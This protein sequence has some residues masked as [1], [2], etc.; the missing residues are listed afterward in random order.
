[1]VLFSKITPPV[2]PIGTLPPW[3]RGY[4]E[5]EAEF[6]QTPVDLPAMV[7]LSAMAIACGGKM[8]VTVR[9]GHVEPLNLYILV[10][11]ESGSRKSPV[12]KPMMKPV[13]DFERDLIDAA[14]KADEPNL[15]TLLV[16]DVTPE[17]LSQLMAA[18][19]GRMAMAS[20]EGGIFGTMAGRYS[21]N[22]PNID[23][24]LK[25]HSGDHFIVNRK[26]KRTEIVSDPCLTISIALQPDVIRS[27]ARVAAFRSRGLLA[28]F[29]Y[30]LPQSNIGYRK[31]DGQSVPD[32][33]QS[34]YEANLKKLLDIPIQPLR[35]MTLT[36][37]AF[38]IWLDFLSRIEPRLRPGA[39]LYPL[40]D[41]A[42]KLAGTVARVA[43]LLHMADR[44]NDAAPWQAP[45]PGP[46]MER[47]IIFGFYLVEHAKIAFDLMGTDP[48]LDDALHVLIWIRASGVQV[49]SK[50]DVY[51]AMQARFRTATQAD[52]VLG[53]LE[54]RGYIRCRPVDYIGHGRK[55]TPVYDVNPEVHDGK[56]A[57]APVVAAT[58]TKP[59]Q[60]PPNANDINDRKDKNPPVAALSSSN[61]V[62]SVNSV[63]GSH[64]PA[65]AGVQNKEAPLA[66]P[67]PEPMANA[68]AGSKKRRTRTFFVGAKPAHCKL[69]PPDENWLLDGF[70]AYSDEHVCLV[71]ARTHEEA[72]RQYEQTILPLFAGD[73]RLAAFAYTRENWGTIGGKIPANYFNLPRAQ[74]APFLEELR[75]ELQ[76]KTVTA[77]AD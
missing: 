17:A 4:V 62:N 46:T 61:S 59:A 5:A 14:E 52:P 43:G 20:D 55:P 13:R 3:L 24:F 32:L 25:A 73:R 15:P 68:S 63:T 35:M 34:N 39:D 7:G 75:Q 31:V 26:G 33:A 51:R 23:V 37:E 65:G 49:F 69:P 57:S 27:L 53:E 18:N 58:P 10:A 70:Y 11:M 54:S 64:K 42:N 50:R 8:K 12:F 72:E 48:V 56:G 38:A 16:D 30:V 6:T 44:T 36:R 74:R 47:A 28:R 40:A 29:V 2:F 76:T 60:K 22:M 9:P 45:I 41:W 21:H 67:D 77:V 19:G 66:D 1:L 71:R